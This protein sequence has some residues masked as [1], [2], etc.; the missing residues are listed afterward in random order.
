VDVAENGCSGAEQAPSADPRGSVRIFGFPSDGHVLHDCH[1]IAVLH[2]ARGPV[3]FR[4]YQFVTGTKL[5]QC[6]VQL[7]PAMLL[8]DPVSEN[9]LAHSSPP[10][11]AA[12]GGLAARLIRAYSI[13]RFGA[14]VWRLISEHRNPLILLSQSKCSKILNYAHCRAEFR[15]LK[16]GMSID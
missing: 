6:G 5:G 3:P 8:A 4:D 7:G 1:L 13:K 12:G 16:E 10:T 2:R 11:P 15:H 14:V 9:T